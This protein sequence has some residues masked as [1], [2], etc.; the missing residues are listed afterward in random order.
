MSGPPS[1]P[2]KKNGR[3]IPRRRVLL[4]GVVIFGPAMMTRDC[5][6]RDLTDFGA[7]IRLRA[8][9]DIAAPIALLVRSSGEAFDADIIWREGEEI[10]LSFTR[11][12]NV[13]EPTLEIEKTARRLW[14]ATS[15]L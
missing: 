13:A 12:L 15:T 5:A 8:A 1:P 7:R 4:G 11:R 10:G 9:H 2:P 14:L 6:V 3:G